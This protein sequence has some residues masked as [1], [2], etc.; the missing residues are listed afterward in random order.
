MW[1]QASKFLSLLSVCHRNKKFHTKIY[2]LFN[3]LKLSRLSWKCRP[4]FPINRAQGT[5]LLRRKDPLSK[6]AHRGIIGASYT[7]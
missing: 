2:P 6:I 1:F 3:S 4:H 7:S 5:L